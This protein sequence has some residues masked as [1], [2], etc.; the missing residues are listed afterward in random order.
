MLPERTARCSGVTRRIIDGGT[1][2]VGAAERRRRVVARA[3]LRLHSAAA[4]CVIRNADGPV[5]PVG[6]VTCHYRC[7]QI[8]SNRVLLPVLQKHK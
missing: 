2:A 1:S 5:G 8:G 3:G 4:E 6:P 7:M